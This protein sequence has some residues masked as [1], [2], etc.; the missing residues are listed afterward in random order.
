M[1]QSGLPSRR[2]PVERVT[3]EV[4]SWLA[5]LGDR[6]VQATVVLVAAG[7][8]GFVALGLSWSGVAARLDAGLQLPFL[9]SGAFAGVALAGC[10]LAIAGV[11][12][13][14]RRSA[15]ERYYLD[16]VIR[17]VAH[18]SDALPKVL[19]VR[20]AKPAAVRKRRVKS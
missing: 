18:L 2:S 14:R 8:G 6:G 19:E 13:D 17:E 20:P 11:H 10:F 3:I 4:P 16:V 12:L 5:A 7:A 15:T 9:V 1:T